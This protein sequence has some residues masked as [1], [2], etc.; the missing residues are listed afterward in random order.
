MDP[1]RD[2]LKQALGQTYRIDRELGG[3][4]MSRVFLATETAFDRKVVLKILPPELLG[5]VSGD[6]FKREIAVAARLQH[7]HIVP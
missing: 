5:A 7:S 4:G 6:R 3:G 1:V 2:Q